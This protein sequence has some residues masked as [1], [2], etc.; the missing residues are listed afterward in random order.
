[1]THNY[2][3]QYQ[4]LRDVLDTARIMATSTP[5]GA[6]KATLTAMLEAFRDAEWL[7]TDVISDLDYELAKDSGTMDM[8]DGE[9]AR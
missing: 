9:D 2:K 8:F 4:D 1:M 7:L 5:D 3:A 6:D